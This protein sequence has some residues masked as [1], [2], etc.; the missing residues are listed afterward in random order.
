MLRERRQRLHQLIDEPGTQLAARP[1]LE[2][3]QIEQQLD[4]REMRV[5]RWTHIDVPF[6]DAH[7]YPFPSF[8]QLAF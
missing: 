3:P 4:D 2:R 7:R 6:E 5:H 8:A 1:I